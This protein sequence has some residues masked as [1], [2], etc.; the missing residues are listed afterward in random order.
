MSTLLIRDADAV[1]TMDDA[2]TEVAG[3]SILVRDGAIEWVGPAS[4]APEAEA[5][6]VVDAAGCVAIPGL[7]NTHHHLYQIM[8]RA[9][10]QDGGLFRWLTELYPIWALLDEEWTHTSASVGLSELALSGCTTST[11]HHYVFPAGAGDL[12]AAEIRAAGEVGIRFHPNRGSMDLGEADGGL[13]PDSVV[14][15]RDA[16]LAETEDAVARFHDRSPGAMLRI[17]VGPCSPFSATRG[18]MKES[19]ALARRLGLRLHTHIAETLDEEDYCVQQF[20]VRPVDLLEDLEFLGSDVWLAHGVHLN[21]SDIEKLAQTSTGVAHCPSSNLRLASGIARVRDL[22]D[23]GAPVGLG[24]DGSASNDSNDIL[25]DVRQAMLVARAGMDPTAMSAREALRLA[26]R[27]SATCLGRDDE[28]GSLEPGKRGDVA[29]FDVTGLPF[30]GTLDPVAALVFCAPRRVR[31]LFVEGRRVV[32][33]GR[34]TR[35]DEEQVS[36]NGHRVARRIAERAAD[37]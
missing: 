14:Q 23:A 17:A 11:D 9:R 5:D 37:R 36:A 1:A 3:G 15:D 2:G 16:I 7:V 8:T 6:E 29:L 31:D 4:E 12:L 10:V 20:G 24:V 32:D 28:I 21:D 18:L 22:L 33:G 19:V 27:G 26:T 13:P 25:A 34:L 35:V 30:A